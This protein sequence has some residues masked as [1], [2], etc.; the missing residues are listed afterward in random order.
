MGNLAHLSLRRSPSTLKISMAHHTHSHL[1]SLPNC[2][3]KYRKARALHQAE[4]A[5]LL[6]FKSASRL[7]RWENGSCLP[8]LVNALRL[9]ILYRTTIEAL[10][11]DLSRSLREE[12][13]LREKS[14]NTHYD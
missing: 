9:S 14:L 4:V 1:I 10:F 7:C 2:L 13:S 5:K 8:N 11:I 3:R 12:L 6:N